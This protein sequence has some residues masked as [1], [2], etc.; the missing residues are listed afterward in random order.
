M[1]A[2]LDRSGIHGKVC[3][4]IRIVYY[5]MFENRHS[6]LI[7]AAAF[8]SRMIFCFVVAFVTVVVGVGI[9]VLG[10]RWLAGF[11]WVDSLLNACMILGGMGPVGELPNDAAKI[12]ASFYALFSG[13]VFISL[14][15]LLIGPLAHR[16]LHRFH[17]AEE[18]V[19]D[20]PKQGKQ[21]RK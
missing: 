8:R 15:A 17:L 16:M 18:D 9:G 3:V 11:S 4:W 19:E 7:S 2:W 21:K 10:Y 1:T 6:P 12:F 5:A 20:E 14:V 13:L